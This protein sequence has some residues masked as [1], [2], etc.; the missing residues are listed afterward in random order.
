VKE[1]Q[2]FAVAVH[3]EKTI[4]KLEKWFQTLIWTQKMT[5]V[6]KERKIC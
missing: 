4:Y 3:D 6:I 1:T 5:Q 2:N